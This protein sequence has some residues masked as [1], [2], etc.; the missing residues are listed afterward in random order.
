[1]DKENLWWRNGVI[2]QIYPRSFKDSDGDGIGD[3]NGIISK[4]DYLHTLGVSA[5]WLSPIYPSPNVDFGYDVCDYTG[6][7]PCFGKMADFDRLLAE[8]H[9]LDI[10]IVMDLVLNHTSDQHPWFMQARQSKDNPYRDWYIWREKPNNWQSVFGGSAW[11][12]DSQTQ[13]YYL[14][15]FYKEQPDV[16]WRNPDLRQAMLDV[17]KFWLDKGVDGFRLDVFNLYFKDRDFRDNPSRPGIRGFDRLKHIHDM[18][19]PEMYMLLKDIRALVDVYPERYLVG[20]TFLDGAE[21]AAGYSGK[22]KLHAAFNFEFLRNSWKPKAY[23]EAI[24]RWENLLPGDVYPNYV[25]N[26]HDVKRSASRFGRGED[27]E[28]LKVAAALLLTQHGTPFLYYG[29][30]IG[31]RDIHLSRRQIQDPVG[32]L[33]W[34]FYSGRDGCRSPMQWDAS[35]YA[36]FS[37]RQAWLPLHEDYMERNVL[38]QRE[39]AGSLY[40]FYKKLIRLRKEE[41]TIQ[42]GIFISLTFEPR[43]ILAY[44]RQDGDE[45]ILVILNFGRRSLRFFMGNELRKRNWRVLLTNKPFELLNNNST[46]VWLKPEQAVILKQI[47]EVA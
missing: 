3:I 19:Q 47:D 27:D 41:K 46:Y 17:F 45:T 42:N 34:P 9:R 11:Q 26:N 28:R 23:L 24:L 25:L 7:H 12:Y 4:L 15:L 20:E 40:H 39:N 21:K 31:M 36:G 10:H 2:Y 32:K 8:A 44:L 30:E 5:I 16:N 22:D 13:E 1:M 33:Y 18:D 37:D 6:I 14:H 29:E 43:S 35:K 38:A